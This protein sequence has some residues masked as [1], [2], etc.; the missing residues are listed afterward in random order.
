MGF[1]RRDFLMRV[2]QAGGFSAAFITM[3]HLGLMPMPEAFAQPELKL[4]AGNGTRVVILGGGIAGL[5]AAYFLSRVLAS[6][7]VGISPHDAVSFG[8]AWVL[9]TAVGLG[10]SLAPAAHAART[11]LNAVLHSE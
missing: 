6:S 1:S 7:L 10:A 2:G 9:M 11:D 4:A 5:V 8:A 3:Q